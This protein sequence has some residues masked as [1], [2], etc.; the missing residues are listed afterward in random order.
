M[1]E[2]PVLG[3]MSI[4]INEVSNESFERE[5]RLDR[6]FEREPKYGT[7]RPRIP[8]NE[9]GALATRYGGAHK[10]AVVQADKAWRPSDVAV[11]S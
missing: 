5:R 6:A 1:L 7:D 8:L 2:L 9:S 4:D 10:P 3:S 11:A